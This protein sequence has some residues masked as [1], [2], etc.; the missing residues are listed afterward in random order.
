MN[1]HDWQQ[2]EAHRLFMISEHDPEGSG[3]VF[4]TH[5]GMAFV[6]L[7]SADGTWHG[8]PEPWNK[9]PPAL[10][11]KWR[12]AKVVSASDLRRYAEFPRG[13]IRWALES[14]DD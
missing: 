9:V 6:A 11:D 3:K 13:S 8:Y 14:D 1:G 7:A 10:K 12:E 4:A 5:R 2:T